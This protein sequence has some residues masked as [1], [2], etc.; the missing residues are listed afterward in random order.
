MKENKRMKMTY[1]KAIRGMNEEKLAKF[2]MNLEVGI[3]TIPKKYSCNEIYCINCK[4]NL[5]CYKKWLESEV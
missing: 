2:I 3:I 4:E 1:F 5:S